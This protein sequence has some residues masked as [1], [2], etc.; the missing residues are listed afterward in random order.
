MSNFDINYEKRRRVILWLAKFGFS[1]RDLLSRMLNVNVNGQGDFFKRLADEG[2]TKETYVPGTRKRVLTL[3]NDGIEEA[4][5][6]NPTLAVRQFRRF[7]LHTLIHSYSIQSFLTA[8]KGIKDFYSETELAKEKYERRPDLLI[9]NSNDVKIAVEIELTQKDTNRIYHNFYA[10]SLDWQK[11]RFD[12][13]MYLFTSAEV[14]KNYAELYDKNPWPKFVTT[15]GNV[16][17]ISRVGSVDPKPIHEHGL[18][19][20]HRFEPYSM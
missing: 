8:Q 14:Q 4:K 17:H 3:S 7:P 10:H 1:T 9:I 12:H 18:V 16:R 11:G 2:I 15:D 20:F 19:V 5:L 6:S 13:V